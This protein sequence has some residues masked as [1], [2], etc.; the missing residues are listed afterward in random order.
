M[1][2]NAPPGE[3]FPPGPRARFHSAPHPKPSATT[4][5]VQSVSNLG[6]RDTHARPELS[7]EMTPGCRRPGPSARETSTERGDVTLHPR[8][9]RTCRKSGASP[10]PEQPPPRRDFELSLSHCA[11]PALLLNPPRPA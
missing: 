5:D 8:G 6:I 7:A 11:G 1:P 10:E 2:G 9:E 4:L 3:G